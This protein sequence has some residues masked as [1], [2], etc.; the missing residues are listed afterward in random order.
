MPGN[1]EFD[2]T[3]FHFRIG[4]ADFYP[5]YEKITDNTFYVYINDNSL[6]V[7]VLYA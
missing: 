6:T 3:P 2:T 4:D 1:L 5:S 7:T